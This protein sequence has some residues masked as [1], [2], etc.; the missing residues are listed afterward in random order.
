MFFL[1]LCVIIHLLSIVQA[2]SQ[3]SN[4]LDNWQMRLFG[5]LSSIYVYEDIIY[6]HN[7]QNQN[8]KIFRV[9]GQVQSRNTYIMCDF[10]NYVKYE[11]NQK[12]VHLFNNGFSILAQWEI[13]DKIDN[14]LIGLNGEYIIIS[15][16]TIFSTI[17]ERFLKKIE[18]QIIYAGYIFEIPIIVIQKQNQICIFSIRNSITEDYCVHSR[19]GGKV[20]EF[21]KTLIYYDNY[22]AYHL[23]DKMAK[24]INIELIRKTCQ[25]LGFSQTLV[26]RTKNN[27]QIIDL[28]GQIEYEF[29]FNL[30]VIEN[31][32][33]QKYYFLVKQEQNHLIIQSLDR[34]TQKLSVQIIEIT[35]KS[36]ILRAFLIDLSQKQ[37]LI[38]YQDLQTV[39][40][41]N[42]S[43]LW[44]TEQSLISIDNIFY[45][46]YENKKQTYKNSYYKSL[47]QNGLYNP[48]LILQNVILR[49]LNEIKDLQEMFIQFINDIDNQ[50]IKKNEME[51]SFGLKQK[52]CF[53]S[54][55][56][57]L[58]CYDT[59]EH[60]LIQKLY[61]NNL[62]QT[63][64][65]VALHQIDPNL[66]QNYDQKV[67]S[68]NHILFYYSDQ[69]KKLY[70]FILDLSYGS[71]QQVASRRSKKIIWTIPYKIESKSS[72][73][74]NL[75]ILID[76][77]YKVFTYPN[78]DH[79]NY[80]EIILYRNDNGVLIGYKLYDK[81]LVKIWTINMRDKI[82]LIR[83]SY[84]YGQDNPRVAN[85]DDRNVIF[86][87]IDHTNFAILTTDEDSLK[88]YI[89][90][91]K[92]GKI[93]FQGIQNEADLNQ[94]INLVFDEHQVFVTYY[95]QAQMIFEIW[96]IEIYHMTIE[97][98]FIKMLEYYY[99]SQDP[100]IKNYYQTDYNAIFLQQVY[101]YPLGIRYLGISKTKNS[102]TK[103]NLL[104]ITTSSQLHQL[105]RNLVSARKREKSHLEY[106][107]WSND[108]I[109]Y[110]YELPIYFQSIL[111][112]NQLFDFEKFSLETTNLES[113]ALLIVYGSDIFFTIISPDKTYDMLQNNFNYNAIIL[114]TILIG[115]A[116]QVLQKLIKSSK[117]EK[118]FKVN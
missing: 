90:N 69:R 96:T 1:L 41:E 82:I 84:Q 9:T 8:G 110:Q 54:T 24:Q 58:L 93:L 70:T 30:Q 108:L 97:C 67:G 52:V 115:L 113:S 86:K 20:I 94:Q 106:S 75:I 7:T 114:T 59:K 100:I 116:I 92:T 57:T 74:Y 50:K 45:Q 111:T 65:L 38:Q 51:Q 60:Q 5:Q 63:F 13:N 73:Y 43:I 23:K 4:D 2:L 26:I 107:L 47:Q 78:N 72:Q 32:E 12:V 10:F 79:L 42:Q 99:F 36:N 39:L 91:A 19:K 71:I 109:S 61:I 18:N 55:Y 62:D 68:K 22:F 88:L 103:K 6:Y 64:K 76:E 118:Q 29:H 31:L 48:F 105:D 21:G 14:C 40:L 117:Q 89:V 49:V 80:K 102:L 34:E 37:F 25:F 27:K 35:N 95:N 81:Q 85:W 15:G 66:A 98:S 44:Q 101:G 53:L 87:L 77:D 56:N 112:Y 3:Q 11:S 16:Q 83:S 46:K 33:T 17:N 104:I 28:K